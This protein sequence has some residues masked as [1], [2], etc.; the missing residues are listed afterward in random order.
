MG[1][2]KKNASGPRLLK[3]ACRT[4]SDIHAVAATLERTARSEKAR[5]MAASVAYL[6]AILRDDLKRLRNAVGSKAP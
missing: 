2:N 4:F 5:C 6:A 3:T 1:R